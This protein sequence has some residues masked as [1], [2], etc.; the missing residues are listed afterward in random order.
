[1]VEPALRPARR[2]D[3]L[4]VYEVKKQALGPYVKQVWGW[5]ED[6]QRDLHRK[7]FNASRLQIVT[8]AGCDVGTI[9]V[10]SDENRFL[11]NTVYLLPEYQNRGIG[12]AL[13][14]GV[15]DRARTQGLP[16]RLGVLKV[17]PARRLYERLGFRVVAET[18]THWKMEWSP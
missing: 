11:I 18:E 4:F 7:E 2:E 9:G 3:D 1:M 13:I 14:R 17:N 8:L 6:V 5:D 16:V 12:S 15:L 10:V